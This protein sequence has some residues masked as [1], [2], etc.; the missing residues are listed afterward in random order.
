MFWNTLFYDFENFHILLNKKKRVWY[1]LVLRRHWLFKKLVRKFY[2]SD[3]NGNP[4]LYKYRQEAYDDFM[5]L[6]WNNKNNFKLINFDNLHKL[7]ERL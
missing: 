2:L 5:N 6:V 3:K 7:Q 4:K 1:I